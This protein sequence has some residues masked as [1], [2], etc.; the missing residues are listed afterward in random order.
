MQF[1]TTLLEEAAK[2]KAIALPIP[3]DEPVIRTVLF[4]LSDFKAASSYKLSDKRGGGDIIV[5]YRKK[6]VEKF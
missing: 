3:L 1:K 2:L 4:K 6:I 5:I